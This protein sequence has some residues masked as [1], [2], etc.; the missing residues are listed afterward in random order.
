MPTFKEEYERAMHK[1]KN[2][3]H[4]TEVINIGDTVICDFCNEDYT[5]SDKQGGM[6]YGSYGTC[7]ECVPRIEASAKKYQEEHL[8]LERALPGET[9]KAFSLRMR[10]GD[11]AITFLK[12]KI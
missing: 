7:P 8:I 3:D 4:S 6:L 12:G 2:G 5:N 9:F 1:I 11:N 10:K